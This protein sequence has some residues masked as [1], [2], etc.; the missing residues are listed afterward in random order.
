MWQIN[1]KFMANHFLVSDLC[2]AAASGELHTGGTEALLGTLQV[3]LQHLK[4][5]RSACIAA[6][7]GT[8]QGSTEGTRLGLWAGY[9]QP[10]ETAC[11]LAALPGVGG[12]TST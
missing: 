7:S 1:P 12:L 10:M 5:G 11:L 8:H 4:A 6:P 9:C 2:T 3:S